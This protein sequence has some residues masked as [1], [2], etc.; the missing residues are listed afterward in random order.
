MSEP[1][2]PSELGFLTEERT[3]SDIRGF[4]LLKSCYDADK[5]FIDGIWKPLKFDLEL[6]DGSK[7]NH[8][9]N[10]LLQGQFKAWIAIQASDH[11]K[12][13][14]VS[15]ER[16]I[17][18]IL[19]VV[20]ILD[21]L[22]KSPHAAQIRKYG[23]KFINEQIIRNL[24]HRIAN[25]STAVER[26]Y[27]WPESLDSHVKIMA[28]A[29]NQS[30]TL[31][32]SSVVLTP[33]QYKAAQ[34]L[35]L[36]ESGVALKEAIRNPIK[37]YKDI[38]RRIYENTIYGHRTF[39]VP[40]HLSFKDLQ[41]APGLVEMPRAPVRS[42]HETTIK[43]TY[44]THRS[45]IE[46]LQHLDM[47]GYEAPKD[48]AI[49]YVAEHSAKFFNLPE[50]DKYRSIPIEIG[51]LGFRRSVEFVLRY[52]SHL[53][54]AF[55]NVAKE[56][57][58]RDLKLVDFVKEYG[59][60]KFLPETLQELKIK[61]WSK[62]IKQLDYPENL[63]CLGL[64]DYIVILYGSIQIIIGILSARRQEEL[65]ECTSENF[66]RGSSSFGF[67]IGKSGLGGKREYTHRPIPNIC[68]NLAEMIGA[69]QNNMASL[70][71]V[72]S[73]L[74]AVPRSQ[75]IGFSGVHH[76]NYNRSFDKACAYF[77][78]W[79]EDTKQSF[80]F[81]QH[82]LRRMFA[83][84]FYWSAFGD[85]DVLR[86]FLAHTDKSHVYRYITE[87]VPGTVLNTIKA[88]FTAEFLSRG[89]QTHSKLE[90]AVV[91]RFGTSAFSLL[92]REEFESYLSHMFEV[93]QIVMEPEFLDQNNGLE[94]QFKYEVRHA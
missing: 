5:W 65:M 77:E 60:S 89:N 42:R 58:S 38:I 92:D 25:K 11:I 93:G 88:E 70:G 32:S 87:H 72:S 56:A 54:E 75:S 1:M 61:T 73:S 62:L 67:Y 28:F 29:N 22:L 19:I 39:S 69:F 94:L 14:G 57:A 12:L 33:A 86:W 76:T 16:A 63:K 66:D 52:G 64:H 84:A 9:K 68:L 37:A 59:I 35:V 83:Q 3:P 40:A 78:L 23:L 82:Q 79:S 48:Y 71:A 31:I 44:S 15:K 36:K 7:L 51:L 74:F 27:N 10:K 34:A 4:K 21:Y 53:L 30:L 13:G 18:R 2:H 43:Q 47:Y 41:E 24:L 49:E 80:N 17:K 20:G 85:L 6:D 81:R 45:C 26:F 8:K 50:P 55:A 90:E 91:T 46:S